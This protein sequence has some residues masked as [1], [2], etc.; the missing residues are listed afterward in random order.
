MTQADKNKRKK[1]KKLPFQKKTAKL[2][3]YI[4]LRSLVSFFRLVPLEPRVRMTKKLVRFIGR[5]LPKFKSRITN[6]LSAAFP[7][8]TE[9]WVE[10]MA[11]A[12]VDHL[13][14]FFG[15]FLQVGKMTGAFREK[16][17]VSHPPREEVVEQLKDGAIVILGHLGNWEWH[18][19]VVASW[20]PWQVYAIARKQSN[21][22]VAE[23]VTRLRKKEF[24][25]TVYTDEGFFR[26][27]KIL[28]K[29]KGIICMVADQD[30]RQHGI[31]IPFFGRPASTF[32]GPAIL[33]RITTKPV[34]FAYSRHDGNRLEIFLEPIQKPDFSPEEDRT[35]WENEFSKSWTDKLEKHAREAVHEYFWVHNRWKTKPETTAPEPESKENKQK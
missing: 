17:I 35:A 24:I 1:A 33:A 4:F 32:L 9:E 31:F 29:E 5:A 12:S 27:K 11:A 10:E 23:Y 14:R 25:E 22:W 19:A 21:P 16:Y 3:E 2:V 13:G 8:H 15:E 18:G 26:F 7:N 30:A 6:N 20:L 34:F 28:E